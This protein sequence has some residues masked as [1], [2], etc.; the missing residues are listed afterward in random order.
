MMSELGADILLDGTDRKAPFTTDAAALSAGLLRAEPVEVAFYNP[1]GW[2][3]SRAV[4]LRVPC[5][6]TVVGADGVCRRTPYPV[7]SLSLLCP[8]TITDTIPLPTCM[9]HQ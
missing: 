9:V 3:V 2:P 4:S 6:A 8:S 1:L 7:F 5:P